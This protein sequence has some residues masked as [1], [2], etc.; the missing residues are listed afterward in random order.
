MFKSTDDENCPIVQFS[1]RSASMELLGGEDS[2]AVK[3]ENN[4]ELTIS[5]EKLVKMMN[6][7]VVATSISGQTNKK[8][9]KLA[10]EPILFDGQL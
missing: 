10:V 5:H 6:F 2:E 9:F 4:N 8:L 7:Y 3:I 1:L